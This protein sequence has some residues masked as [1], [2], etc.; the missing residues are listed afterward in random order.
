M[1]ATFVLFLLL[2]LLF[3]TSLSDVVASSP[4]PQSAVSGEPSKRSAYPDT[5]AASDV[6][7]LLSKT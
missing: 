6:Y 2:T 7:A 1:H 3:L 5:V 4:A